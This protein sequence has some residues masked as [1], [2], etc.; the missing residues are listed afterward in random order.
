[1]R[2]FWILLWAELL[3]HVLSTNP[4]VSS[5]LWSRKNIALVPVLKIQIAVGF[6]AVSGFEDWLVCP[7]FFLT[8]WADYISV[9]SEDQNLYTGVSLRFWRKRRETLK[10]H[11]SGASQDDVDLFREKRCLAKT[12]SCE[13]QFPIGMH[14]NLV[15][16]FQWKKHRHA[17]IV[18]RKHRL[19]K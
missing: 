7:L 16:A 2:W 18:H 17:K 11:Y 9:A 3:S 1:M 14:W 8:D 4:F 5:W 15:N 13:T 10:S 6:R 12:L 19:A